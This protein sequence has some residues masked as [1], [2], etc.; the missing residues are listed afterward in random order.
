MK[1]IFITGKALFYIINLLMILGNGACSKNNNDTV[2]PPL[3]YS[4]PNQVKPTTTGGMATIVLTVSG[5]QW[6]YKYYVIPEYEWS[7]GDNI[8]DMLSQNNF[9][10]LYRYTYFKNTI[11]V[12]PGTSTNPK[13][14][15]VAVQDIEEHATISGTNMLSWWK[16]V[17]AT[18]L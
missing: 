14:Y 8:Q 1:K 11:E 10:R 12:S 16:K 15:W 4:T 9:S 7:A 17:A 2:N 13:Y 18:G 3:I 5:G 6:P